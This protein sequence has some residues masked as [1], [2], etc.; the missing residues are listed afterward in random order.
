MLGVSLWRAG[1]MRRMCCLHTTTLLPAAPLA[2]LT[3][4][5]IYEP[6]RAEDQI[7]RIA[8]GVCCFNFLSFIATGQPLVAAPTPAPHGCAAA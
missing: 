6:K 2:Q 7:L 8:S 5:C 3:P 1:F 4:T